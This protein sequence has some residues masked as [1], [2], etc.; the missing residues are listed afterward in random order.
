M[1]FRSILIP[2]LAA[3]V[4]AIVALILAGHSTPATTAPATHSSRRAAGGHVVITIKSY[5]Y[6]PDRITV[7]PGTMI[8][9]IN[10]DMT[11]HTLTANNATFDTGTIQPGQTKRI[12][13]TKAGAYPY[14]CAFHAF[15]TGTITVSG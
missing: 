2:S 10:R 7:K 11:Q 6:S 13:V 4:V 14:H 1:R 15:M 5:G 9:V 3:V 8:T 12:T